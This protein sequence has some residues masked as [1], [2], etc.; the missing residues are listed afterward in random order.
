MYSAINESCVIKSNY[1]YRIGPIEHHCKDAMELNQ[2][3]KLSL[4]CDRN[5]DTS[6]TGIDIAL[7]PNLG[8]VNKESPYP[9]IEKDVEQKM[10]RIVTRKL[11][12]HR[13]RPPTDG[14]RLNDN[15]FEELNITYSFTLEACCDPL[16]LSGH[17]NLPFYS[18][19]KKKKY[20]DVSGQSIYCNP[21]CSLAIKCVENIRA[22][23][24]FSPLNMK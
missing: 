5:I 14:W 16:G 20:H 2:E 12:N 7:S 6:L 22:C 8:D 4:R 21:P 11:F 19:Q 1:D 23:H 9:L 15:E 17:R 18:E 10:K 13:K 3:I 24:S